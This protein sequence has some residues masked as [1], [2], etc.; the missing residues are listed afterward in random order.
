MKQKEPS[1]QSIMMANK[2]K[3]LVSMMYR[4]YFTAVSVKTVPINNMIHRQSRI[5]LR[6]A[7][8]VI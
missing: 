3:P 2:K 1:K 6:S 7:A 4:K 5:C 8:F